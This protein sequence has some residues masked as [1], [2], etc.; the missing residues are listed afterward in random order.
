MAEKYVRQLLAINCRHVSGVHLLATLL[1][2]A[3]AVNKGKS[4]DPND[5]IA[6]ERRKK[7]SSS[8]SSSSSN[9][10]EEAFDLLQ[11]LVCCILQF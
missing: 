11:R 2:E 3:Y 5:F 9:L 1:L 6:M 8:S 10:M 4:R 7:S